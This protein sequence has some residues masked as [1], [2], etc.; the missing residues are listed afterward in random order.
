MSV[1]HENEQA[2]TGLRKVIDWHDHSSSVPHLMKL[3]L[4][5]Y[6]YFIIFDYWND[7][8]VGEWQPFGIK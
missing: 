6:G 1:P 2:F 7:K 5:E 8:R 4:E 3:F